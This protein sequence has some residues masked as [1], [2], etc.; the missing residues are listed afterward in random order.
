[1]TNFTPS[2]DLGLTIFWKTYS[3]HLVMQA[4]RFASFYGIKMACI[5]SETFECTII[6]NWQIV[7]DVMPLNNEKSFFMFGQLAKFHNVILLYLRCKLDFNKNKI[8]LLNS[9]FL[10]SPLIT[11]ILLWHVECPVVIQ[12]PSIIQK[13]RW[14]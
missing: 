6:K 9:K 8:L 3:M 13:K 4:S 14:Y 11:N 10:I 1:M 12:I 5:K 2:R 7:Y